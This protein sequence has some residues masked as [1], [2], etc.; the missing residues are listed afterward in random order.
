M[1]NIGIYLVIGLKQLYLFNHTGHQVHKVS[2]F[3]SAV[4][5]CVIDNAGNILLND[6]FNKELHLY[7]T[8][9]KIW[10]FAVNF[11]EVIDKYYSYLEEVIF[12]ID[13]INIWATGMFRGSDNIADLI[14]FNRV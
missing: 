7:E 9:K 3:K 13:G 8:K 4:S 2:E 5:L 11:R 12:D 6:K 10:L 14:H 1:T